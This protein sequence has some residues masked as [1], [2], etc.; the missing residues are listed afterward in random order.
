[1]SV[2]V[3]QAYDNLLDALQEVLLREGKLPNPRA[4]VSAERRRRQTVVRALRVAARARIIDALRRAAKVPRGVDPETELT[5]AVALVTALNGLF[6]SA[7]QPPYRIN[8][9]HLERFDMRRRLYTP[10]T[11][12]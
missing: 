6:P 8:G 11:D 5:A 7:A 1:M 10:Y 12:V 4:P 3:P 2:S 9:L